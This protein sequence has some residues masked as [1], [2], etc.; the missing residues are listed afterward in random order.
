MIRRNVTT[1]NG[2]PGW[3]LISQVEHARIS[4][5]FAESWIDS[6]TANV[7]FLPLINPEELLPA[8]YHHDDG[9]QDWEKSPEVDPQTGRPL[10][11]TE[12]P[13]EVALEI[14]R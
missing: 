1:E 10:A 8:I 4:G 3:L 5:E 13:L 2:Q 6:P 11:F 9:W 7:T 12:M 14:W